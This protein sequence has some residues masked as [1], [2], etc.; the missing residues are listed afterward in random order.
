M[1]VRLLK[2]TFLD[3]ESNILIMENLEKME[4]HK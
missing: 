4:K 1:S 3:C 2:R